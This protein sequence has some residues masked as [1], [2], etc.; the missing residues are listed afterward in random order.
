LKVGIYDPDM[1][2]AIHEITLDLLRDVL[3]GVAG[4]ENFDDEARRADD[5][6]RVAGLSGHDFRW[7]IRDI[8]ADRR[9][10]LARQPDRGLTTDDPAVRSTLLH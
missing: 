1:L 10:R 8:D 5:D 2:D 6:G 3:L 9:L 4:R 7:N